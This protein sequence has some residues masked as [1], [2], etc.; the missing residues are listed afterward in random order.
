MSKVTGPLA[1]LDASGQF[2]KTIVY[3]KWKGRNYGRLK[4]TPANPQSNDQA[5]A[6]L[7]LGCVGKTNKMVECLSKGDS[8][9]SVLYTQIL[10]KTP[11]DQSWMS[12]FAK[13]QLGIANANIKAFRL[14]YTALG[15]AAKTLWGAA[16]ATI[17]VPGFDIGYGTVDPI[18]A[19]E[20]LFIA[21]AAGWILGLAI[22]PQDPSDMTESEIDAFAAAFKYAA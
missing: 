4:V 7:Y 3:S 19:G 1:S 16:A 20:A 6:R 17:P 10:A 8:G 9:D 13:T 18:P 22:I 5:E 15:S 11:S 2:G 12:Y 14:A 21:A